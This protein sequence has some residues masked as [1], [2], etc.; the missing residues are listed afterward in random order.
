MALQKGLDAIT[1]HHPMTTLG[2]LNL[3]FTPLSPMK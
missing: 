3:A 1:N 2:F